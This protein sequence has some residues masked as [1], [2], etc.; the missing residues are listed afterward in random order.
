MLKREF[1]GLIYLD[2]R[3]SCIFI[4]YN[5]LIMKNEQKFK[6]AISA[7]AAKIAGNINEAEEAPQDSAKLAQKM[8]DLKSSLSPAL[9]SI[10]SDEEFA[11]VIVSMREM[12][13]KLSDVAAKAGLKLAMQT[14][15]SSKPVGKDEPGAMY[16]KMDLPDELK[17]MNESFDRMKTLAGIK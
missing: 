6:E 7:L 13:P 14:M 3:K 12:M 9:N 4:L 11:N 10:N 1:L 5:K 17:N 16:D 15:A 2:Q 8:D